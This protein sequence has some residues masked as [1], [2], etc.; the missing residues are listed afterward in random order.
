MKQNIDINYF[1]ESI[2][3]KASTFGGLTEREEIDSLP[4]AL[5]E[6]TEQYMPEML[7]EN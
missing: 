6:Q 4:V 1:Q 3:T 5:L 7:E 2:K